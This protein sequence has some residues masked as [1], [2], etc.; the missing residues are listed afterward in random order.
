[1]ITYNSSI[2]EKIRNE[3]YFVTNMLHYDTVGI[4]LQGSQN[5]G[6]DW[7][8][9]DV[10]TKAITVPSLK[11]IALN[12]PPISSTH[13]LPSQEHIDLK[14]IRLM[15]NCFRKQNTNFL[16]ILFTPYVMLNPNYKEI[17]YPLIENREKIAHYNNYAFI[18]SILGT[19]HNEYKNLLTNRP[20][21]A[22]S[23][24]KYGYDV[25]CLAHIVRFAELLERCVNN[26]PFEDCLQTK[27]CEEI[28]AIKQG[29]YRVEDAIKIAENADKSMVFIKD[30]YME[31][32]PLS[33][34]SDVD[35]LLDSVLVNI[36][37]KKFKND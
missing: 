30:Q 33:V 21:A 6:C 1:M 22:E 28:I 35:E 26:E 8:K 13:I 34:N 37:Q 31:N 20:G 14:D 11:E 2:Q 5:Y 10:D 15:F 17:F 18:N 23:V 4:F 27:K 3:Y 29:F 9:S 32:N 19:A 24:E 36:F 25:K 16:E 12:A 7:E